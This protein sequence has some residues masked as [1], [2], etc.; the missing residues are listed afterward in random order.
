MTPELNGHAD[1]GFG[2]VADAFVANFEQRGEIGAACCLY[3]D[4]RPV[5]DLWAG[6]ADPATGRPWATDS[7]PLVFSTTKGITA[8]AAHVLVQRGLLELD[9]PVARYWPEFAANG[10]GEIPVRWVLCHRAGLADVVGDLTLDDIVAWDPVVRAIAAQAP[11]W[12]PGTLH[13][14]HARSYG[15]IIGEIVR[16]VTGRTIGQF[17]TDEV[18]APVGAEFWIGLPVE[19]EPLVAPV[20]PPE[21]P[22]DPAMRELMEAVMS[23]E[24]MLGRVMTG[25]SDLFRYDERWNQRPLHTAEMPSSN[26]ICTA[27][28]LARIYAATVGETGGVRL[29]EPDV[30]AGACV[31]QAEGPDHIIGVASRFGS[32]FMLG[33]AMSPSAPPSAFGHPGAGGSLGCADPEAGLAFGYVMNRMKLDFSAPDLRATSLLKRAYA[34]LG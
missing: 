13:G 31:V 7:M 23:R 3:V 14:Y 18:A 29:L 27:R 15:W 1:V 22:S 4:G 8:I 6:V 12:E 20:T 25:P 24:H 16:R 30:L 21:T 26:G 28:D 11:N 33:D 9:A 19:L 34:S 17:V 10:K 5:V 32:G 2:A